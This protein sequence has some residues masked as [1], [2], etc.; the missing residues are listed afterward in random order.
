MT[1][2]PSG[3][4]RPGLPRPW[5]VDAA[6]L[7]VDGVL[8]D[9]GPSFRECVRITVERVQRL[10]GVEEP[11][12]PSLDDVRA[13]K[14]TG[15]FNDD[16]DTAIA[17]TAV[18]AGG[19]GRQL[20]AITASVERAGGGLR[21]L[22]AVAP[23]L[24]RIPGRLVLR[25]FDEHYWG[26][27]EFARRFG[28]SP[29]HDPPARG[30]RTAERAL[31]TPDLPHRLR[32]G[33]VRSVA[34]VTGRTPLELDDALERL[35][36]RRVDVDAI[37][38]GDM[39]RKPDPACLD[40]VVEATSATSLVYAGDVRD[41]WELVRRFTAERDGSVR[42]LSVVVGAE[43]QSLRALGCDA[44]LDSVAELPALLAEL[45]SGIRRG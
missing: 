40:R 10:L 17:L 25:V 31:A 22:R 18:G 12:V 32:A 3:W 19:R 5:P 26:A 27:E 1:G 43:S 7:D 21:G 24:P 20:A 13:L 16:I 11:W 42:A 29:Q 35:G 41:D 2:P 8:L 4:I 45:R 23:D 37:V 30:L 38:T 15:G 39:A 6:V 33:G 14:R 34:V 36:W 9:V 44:T 28:E